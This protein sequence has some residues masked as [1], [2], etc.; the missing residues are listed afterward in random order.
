MLP[1]NSD[2]P[3]HLPFGINNRGEVI[4][5]VEAADGITM[6]P[7]LWKPLDL[8]R[9]SYSKPI[10]LPTSTEFPFGYVD[11]INEFGQMAGILFGEAGFA[12]TQAAHWSLQDLTA[13]QVFPFPNE[14]AEAWKINNLNIVIG[15]YNGG[16]CAGW[17]CGAAVQFRS[18]AKDQ[19]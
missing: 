14:N 12:V 9:S 8:T 6:I 15:N 3:C 11:G 5:A 4:G 2:Y 17:L 1:V 19:H 18:S 10:L 7:A 13:V 16:D